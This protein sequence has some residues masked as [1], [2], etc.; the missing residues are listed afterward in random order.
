MT[1]AATAADGTTG[2]LHWRCWYDQQTHITCLVDTLPT[3]DKASL[4][5][6]PV[7]L[8]GIVRTMRTNPA[9]L[10]NKIVHIPLLTEPLDMEFTAVLAKSTVC[11]SRR[12]CSVNFSST[13]P[14]SGEIVALLTKHL[15]DRDPGVG[16]AML[17]RDLDDIE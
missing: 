9:S 5:N 2:G 16:L 15:P 8:P 11:G 10:R 13:L 17:D 14:P 12:D 1:T 4:D 6:L 3:A 7:N